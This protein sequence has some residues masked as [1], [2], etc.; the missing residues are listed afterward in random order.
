ML[1]TSCF[2]T[3]PKALTHPYIISKGVLSRPSMDE[4]LEGKSSM[5]H[6]LIAL[7]CWLACKKN[8]K[9]GEVLGSSMKSSGCW[10]Q[11]L[12]GGA[13]ALEAAWASTLH[14]HL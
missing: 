2:V 3:R 9:N 12:Q 14:S 8:A 7:H 6:A 10:R 5:Q 1:E 13:A 4:G 11:D